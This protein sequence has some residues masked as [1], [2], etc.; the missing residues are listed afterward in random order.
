M[1]DNKKTAVIT[2]K[3]LD[4]ELAATLTTLGFACRGMQ[5]LKSSDIKNAGDVCY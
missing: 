4:L 1:R 3:T 5:R 2:D